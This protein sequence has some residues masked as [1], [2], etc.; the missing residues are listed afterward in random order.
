MSM[1]SPFIRLEPLHLN[2]IPSHPRWS[3]EA[4]PC[5]RLD[6]FLR[7]VLDQGRA[8]LLPTEF[9]LNFKSQGTK[10]APPSNNEIEVF[11]K[12]FHA[13]D[14]EGLDWSTQTLTR[15][16]PS[17]SREEHWYARRSLHRNRAVPGTA[18]WEQFLYGVRDQHSK[19]EF[20]FV[21]SIYDARLI[22]DW[23][24]QLQ[25]EVPTGLSS[26]LY[27]GVRYTHLTMAI[28]EMCHKMPTGVDP[29]CFPV[30]VTT[31]SCSEHE[32]IAVTLPVEIRASPIAFYSSGRNKKEGVDSQQR[33]S[34]TVGRYCAVE[35]VHKY[36]RHRPS[37]TNT[38][39]ASSADIVRKITTASSQAS[40][41]S[42]DRADEEIEWVMANT[43]HAGGN[44][45]LK[46]QQISSPAAIVR[47][48]GSFLKW[49][50]RVP[51]SEITRAVE[52]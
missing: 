38:V 44:L 19:H 48:V 30:L 12:T 46:L 42:L 14:M 41:T 27:E 34:A 36:P 6:V 35:R 28:Y 7:T 31:A 10:P 21:S 4:L 1:N 51:Q 25:D 5:P 23:V 32:F 47:D 16:R 8:L 37:I 13:A 45:P 43:C 17:K 11:S 40:S 52:D 22:C 33:R 50:R 29:R 3:T 2:D 18:S 24:D 15:P 9:S 49:I 26:V 20:D 39:S